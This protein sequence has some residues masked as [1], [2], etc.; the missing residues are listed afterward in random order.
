MRVLRRAVTLVLLVA[1]WG[2]SHTVN[3]RHQVD[4]IYISVQVNIQ[5]QKELDSFFDFEDDDS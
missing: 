4:P 5:V 1:I 2:C 3:V